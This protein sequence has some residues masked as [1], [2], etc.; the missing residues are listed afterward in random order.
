MVKTALAKMV[1]VKVAAVAIGVAVAGGGVALAASS[2]MAPTAG[3]GKGQ[4]ASHAPAHPNGKPTTAPDKSHEGTDGKAGAPSPSLIGLCRAYA[5]GAGDNP[6]KAL[7]NPAFQALIAA[8]GGKDHVAG[9]CE[10][11]LADQPPTGAGGAPSAVPANKPT[12]KPQDPSGSRPS[13]K[14]TPSHPT[15]P[16][17]ADAD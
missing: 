5:A 4:A 12:E 3:L 6:G 2:G 13:P 1:S 15:P 11:T 16:N 8:S 7:D 9:Y 10:A 14:A 17:S